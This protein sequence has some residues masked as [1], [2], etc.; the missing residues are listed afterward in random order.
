LHHRL[1]LIIRSRQKKN[2]EHTK[3]LCELNEEKTK[4]IEELENLRVKSLNMET[5]LSKEQGA[6]MNKL[7]GERKAVLKATGEK[8]ELKHKLKRLE[9]E[10]KEI[11]ENEQR[12]KKEYDD[13]FEEFTKLQRDHRNIIQDGNEK[14]SET[15]RLRVQ[16]TEKEE[17]ASQAEQYRVDCEELAKTMRQMK[18]VHEQ[19]LVKMRN[20]KN[21]Y[22]KVAILA[23]RR[24]A[25]MTHE[26]LQSKKEYE[27]QLTSAEKRLLES[28]RQKDKI[29]FQLT[30][31]SHSVDLNELLEDNDKIDLLM[32]KAEASVEM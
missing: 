20:E 17:L 28:E 16:L 30:M 18:E 19:K 32:K 27:I 7:E 31:D 24:L 8:K 2:A 3:T 10:L 6:L 11:Q 22:K 29:K 15:M 23:K 12:T 5:Q 14:E 4:I 13:I 21:K 26:L 1:L 25:S 9:V